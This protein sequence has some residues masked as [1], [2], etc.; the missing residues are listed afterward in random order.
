MLQ[1]LFQN[2]DKMQ[3][4]QYYHNEQIEWLY[5]AS[6]A[7]EGEIAYVSMLLY[8][9]MKGV[10]WKYVFV[11]NINSLQYKYVL[12]NT[13]PIPYKLVTIEVGQL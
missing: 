9:D 11:S 5:E 8:V 1:K 4:P 3:L 12:T 13:K 10:C 7:M 6:G 2:F